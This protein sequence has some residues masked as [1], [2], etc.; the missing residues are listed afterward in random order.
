MENLE[1]KLTDHQI[2]L[3]FYNRDT[4][5]RNPHSRIEVPQPP[6]GPELSINCTQLGP[7]WSTKEKK[8]VLSEWCDFLTQNPRTFTKLGFGTRMP[9]ELFDATCHQQD[10][11]RLTINWGAYRDLSAIENLRKL[12][13]LELGSAA[14]V[15]S[16][17]PISK[18]PNLLGLYVENFQKVNDYSDLVALKKLQTLGISGMGLG[19]PKNVKV[20]SLEFLREMP[21]LRHLSLMGVTLLSK[22][23]SPI[24]SLKRLEHLTLDPRRDL[25]SFVHDLRQLPKL[26]WGLFVRRPDMYE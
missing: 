9:Q 23:Y 5:P 26:K 17:A 8:R 11:E 19:G 7:Y 6:V 3:G 24:L 1:M 22:D 21:Q 13:L 15:E 10:L 25:K 14:S 18:L 2:Q 12:K 4:E 20:N 16:V